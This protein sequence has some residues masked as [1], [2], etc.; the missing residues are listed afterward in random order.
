[1]KA[2]RA[3]VT[4]LRHLTPCFMFRFGFMLKKVQD[5]TL[6]MLAASAGVVTSAGGDLSVFELTA[7]N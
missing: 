4:E 1:M 6:L 5:V 3:S 2:V 7:G